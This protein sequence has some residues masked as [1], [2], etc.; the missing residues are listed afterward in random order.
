[1]LSVEKVVKASIESCVICNDS[2]TIKTQ[3]F[4]NL[5]SSAEWNLIPL[6]AVHAEEK[7]FS[8]WLILIEAYETLDFYFKRKGFVFDEMGFKNFQ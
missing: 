1:M 6:C 4:Q 3:I 7:Y 8:G 5:P 2:P